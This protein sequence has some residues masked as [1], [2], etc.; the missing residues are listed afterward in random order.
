MAGWHVRVISNRYADSVRLMS[1]SRGV[2]ERPGV[3]RC[4]VGMGTPANLELL[5]GLGAVADATPADIVIAVEAD[6]GI[7]E[8]A[9]GFAEQQLSARD[10]VVHV[11]RER[12]RTLTAAAQELAGANVALISLP[13]DYAT[14]EAHRALSAGMHVFLFSDHVPLEAEIELKRRGADLGLL[15]MGPECGTA[16]LGGVALG[17]A[18]VVRSGRVGIIAAAGT[19]AQESACLLDAAGVGV[20]HIVGVGGRDLSREVG[21]TMF[22]L[23]MG[24]LA[25]DTNTDTLLL[26][27]KS[28][29]PDGVRALTAAI[30]EGIRIVASFVGWTGGDLP[31][32]VHPTLEAGAAAAAGTTPDDVSALEQGVDDRRRSVSGERLLGLYSGGSLA[33]EAATL[34][35]PELGALAGNVSHAAAESDGTHALFDLGEAEYTQGRPHPM[36]DLD[37]RIGMLQEAASDPRTGCVLLDVVLG[38]AGHPDPAGGLAPAIAAVAERAVV[39]A[40]VCG[41]PRDPQDSR[42]QTATLRDAGAIVAPSNAA[43]A[44]LA[45][46]AVR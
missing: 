2:R 20:S 14:L 9:L 7:V 1:V 16:M 41:T 39:I 4:E 12:P 13:G 37:V 15:V 17:F 11:E 28:P 34:L 3:S 10:G 45:A 21:A 33:H 6:N 5:A 36:V 46:R 22:R 31:F 18:N 40:H 43:A 8:D 19:G 30:P 26:V 38:Y 29:T 23:G 44:R 42:R 32:E 35:E 24:L 27:S 25:D